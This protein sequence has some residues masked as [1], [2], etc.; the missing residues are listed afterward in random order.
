MGETEVSKSRGHLGKRF[1]FRLRNLA[2]DVFEVF[3][4]LGFG[5][6]RA[7]IR[8][9]IAHGACFGVVDPL[10][11]RCLFFDYADAA[12]RH[13]SDVDCAIRMDENRTSEF[14]RAA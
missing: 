4:L 11:S 3:A 12:D 7:R 14:S 10:S 1:D 2:L 9:R 13:S 8:H 6:V 5:A